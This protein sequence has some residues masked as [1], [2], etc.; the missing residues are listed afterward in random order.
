M[1]LVRH[2]MIEDV[3]T[4]LRMARPAHSGNLPPGAAPLQDRVQL[5]I[6]SFTGQ[7]L[8]GGRTDMFVLINLDTDTVVGTSSLVTGKGSNEQTS[9]F[10]RVR[11]REHYSEDL[12]VGQMPMTVQLGE[13]W[14]GPTDLGV[15]TLSPSIPS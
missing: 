15:A 13:D 2:A 7:I 5:S 14:S 3:P 1:F 4:L 10:L 6:E 9:R 12:Q 8:E 11:R